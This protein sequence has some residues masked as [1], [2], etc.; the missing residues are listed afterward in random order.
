MKNLEWIDII[1]ILRNKE[2]HVLE[3]WQFE[4]FSSYFPVFHIWYD[5]LFFIFEKELIFHSWGN[6]QPP[7]IQTHI[8][9]LNF[10]FQNKISTK[11]FDINNKHEDWEI[12]NSLYEYFHAKYL[13]YTNKFLF[14]DNKIIFSKNNLK[15]TKEFELII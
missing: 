10:T 4:D 12:I 13:I 7:K 8:F 15:D 6:S 1:E 14:I 9:H 5:N 2:M 3:S 11:T